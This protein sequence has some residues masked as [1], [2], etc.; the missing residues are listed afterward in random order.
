MTLK[1]VQKINS[2]FLSQYIETIHDRESCVHCSRS[3]L[4][5][6]CGAYAANLIT[7]ESMDWLINKYHNWTGQAEHV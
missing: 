7:Y 5:M 1:E 6:I 2:D 4:E 3:P